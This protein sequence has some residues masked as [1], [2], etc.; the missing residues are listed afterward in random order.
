M[1]C[2][3]LSFRNPDSIIL[4]VLPP[5][6]QRR[7]FH[8]AIA[9]GQRDSGRFIHGL[10][11]EVSYVHSIHIPL[12]QTQFTWPHLTLKDSK[13]TWPRCR[14]KKRRTSTWVNSGISGIRDHM[15]DRTFRLDTVNIWDQTILCHTGLSCALQGVSQHSWHLVSITDASSALPSPSHVNQTYLQMV[16]CVL[17]EEGLTPGLV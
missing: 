11:L 2:S 1:L 6:G 16:P 17:W 7:T 14:L 5:P 3:V 4:G 8:S 10:V 12:N 9:G 15:Q 13:E